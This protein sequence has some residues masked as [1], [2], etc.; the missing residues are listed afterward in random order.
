MGDTFYFIGNEEKSIH[1]NKLI[2]IY[3]LNFDKKIVH[4]LYKKYSDELWLTLTDFQYFTD[5]TKF[6]TFYIKRD[7]NIALDIKF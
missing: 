2:A 1:D 7:G 3:V 4:T 6:I 5:I